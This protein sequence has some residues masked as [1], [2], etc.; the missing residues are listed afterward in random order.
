M[1]ACA[2]GVLQPVL[3]FQRVFRAI[4]HALLSSLAVLGR[5][6]R[7]MHYR[8]RLSMDY[9]QVEAD[10]CV[11]GGGLWHPESAPTAAMRRNIDHHPERIKLVLMEGKMRKEFLKGAP[12]QESKVVKAFVASNAGNALKTKPKVSANALL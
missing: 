9:G 4:S 12:Q 6:L 11:A 7:D 2:H 1:L 5:H 8:S 10:N 3:L